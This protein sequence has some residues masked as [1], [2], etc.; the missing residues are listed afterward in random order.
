M[1]AF[2]SRRGEKSPSTEQAPFPGDMRR[3]DLYLDP[4]WQQRGLGRG[5]GPSAPA[6]QPAWGGAGGTAQPGQGQGGHNTQSDGQQEALK[7]LVF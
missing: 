7:V 4:A 1:L 3:V 5:M 2:C 6:A